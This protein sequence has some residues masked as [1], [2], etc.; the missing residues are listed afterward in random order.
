MKTGKPIIGLAGGI[1]SGKST[2]ASILSDLGAG[3]ISSDKLNH[4]ELNT[5]EVVDCLRRWWG[6]R[7]I[8]P[9]GRADR[10][11]I[12]GIVTDDQ[13][14]RRQLEKLVHPRI[15]RRQNDLIAN[16][17]VD[18]NISAIVLDVPLLYEVGLV[19]KCDCVIY[20]EAD[21]EVRLARVSR[22]RDWTA[23]DLKRLEKSQLSLATKRKNA[24][25]IVVNNS[26]IT[27][28]RREVEDVFSR[29]LSGS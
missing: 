12:R 23:E 3:V 19:D 9:N 13:Q 27:S 28:L 16:Y 10:D 25:Y 6:E 11:A 17:L 26:D 21:A 1:G 5:P 20:V 29:I 15:I 22:D 4:E 24:D 2:I 18:P 8:T 7:V 14:A